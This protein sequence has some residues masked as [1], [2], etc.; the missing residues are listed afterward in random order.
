[1]RKIILQIHPEK[2][3]SDSETVLKYSRYS[4]LKLS[5]LFKKK[6]LNGIVT[7]H[8]FNK[9]RTCENILSVQHY[10]VSVIQ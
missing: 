10:I 6:I 3:N 8:K 2:Y 7:K 1:M 4:R 9:V 5:Y